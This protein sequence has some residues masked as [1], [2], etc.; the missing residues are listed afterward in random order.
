MKVQLVGKITGKITSVATGQFKHAEMFLKSLGY[1]VFNPM[2]KINQGL[3][4]EEQM[5]ICLA[6]IPNVEMLVLLEDWTESPGAR[7]EVTKALELDKT[8]TT[9]ASIVKTRLYL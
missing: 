7:R 9:F 4:Y 5:D 3:P 6:N 2:E 8:M 1:D